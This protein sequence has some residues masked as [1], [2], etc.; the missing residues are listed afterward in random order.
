MTM[1]SFDDALTSFVA[2]SKAIIDQY[3]ARKGY[4]FGADNLGY[5][6]GKRYVRVHTCDAEMKP[7]SAY[8]FVDRTNGDVLKPAGW[9]TPAKHARGNIFAEDN[10]LS[11]MGPYGPEYL[12]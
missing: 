5:T 2:G 9:K 12:R 7:Q 8:C 3:H 6:V 11:R 10:G 1:T 4:T